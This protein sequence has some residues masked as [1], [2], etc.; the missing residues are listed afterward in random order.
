MPQDPTLA[1]DGT[2]RVEINAE[3]MHAAFS[4]LWIL[5]PGATAWEQ[6]KE[7]ATG[8]GFPRAVSYDVTRGTFLGWRLSVGTAAGSSPYRITFTL[9]QNGSVIQD[10][11]LV[12]AGATDSGG[13]D[14]DL[15]SV[16]LR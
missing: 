5:P 10:G 6:M 15:D 9:T 11:V 13:Q 12:I 4:R 1:D 2:V 8:G 3:T 16:Q 7:V 14:V